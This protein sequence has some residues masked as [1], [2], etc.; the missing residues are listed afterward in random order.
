MQHRYEQMTI[1]QIERI[2]RRLQVAAHDPRCANL[3]DV[4]AWWGD[5]IAA[6]RIANGM[7]A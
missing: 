1:I 7:E 2:M 3:D 5:A 4:L 6:Y